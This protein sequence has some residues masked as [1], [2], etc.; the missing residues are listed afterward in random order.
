[1]QSI[2]AAVVAAGVIVPPPRVRSAPRMLPRLL[3]S[4]AQAP[5]HSRWCRSGSKL[6]VKLA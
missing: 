1:M 4:A 2:A 3:S 6:L 5:P